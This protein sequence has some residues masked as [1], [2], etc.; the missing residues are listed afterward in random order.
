MASTNHKNLFYLAFTLIKFLIKHPAMLLFSLPLALGW[1]GYESFIARPAFS[2]KG[3]PEAQSWLNPSTFTRIFRSDAFLVGYSDLRGN[4]L[5]VSYKIKAVPK[6]YKRLKRPSGFKPDWRSIN[7]VIHK[8]YTHT[9]YDR[10]HMAPNYAISS[11]Y[12]KQAQLETFV[13]TNITPQ[14]PNL[15]RKLWQRLEAAEISHFTKYADTIWVTTGTIFTGSKKMLK[16]DSSI[17]IPDAFYKVYAMQSKKGEVKLLAFLMPQN[18]KGNESLSKYLVSVDKIEELT[19]LDF[20][21]DLEDKLEDALEAKVEP[22]SW[23]VK[24]VANIPSRY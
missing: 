11:L 13:M 5:W 21:S 20:F 3:V 1:Y 17:E 16:K 14:K 23:H 10:G 18:V 12:G 4:P 15:N 19:G 9:G 24:A 22:K 6:N 2:F 7:K 8:D